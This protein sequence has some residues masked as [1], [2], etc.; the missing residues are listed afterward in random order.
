MGL[1]SRWRPF[2]PPRHLSNTGTGVGLTG[3]VDGDRGNM[4]PPDPR[5]GIGIRATVSG[6]SGVACKY[7]CGY[8]PEEQR[9]SAVTGA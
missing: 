8:L 1:G 6:G 3:I 7:I 4:A 2:S 9:R 5:A